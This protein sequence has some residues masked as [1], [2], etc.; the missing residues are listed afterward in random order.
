MIVENSS[1]LSVSLPTSSK[2]LDLF[3]ELQ[4]DYSIVM[5][6]ISVICDF[7]P[8][9]LASIFTFKFYQG[10]EIAHP[11]YA[12]IFMN[13]LISTTATYLSFILTLVDSVVNNNII[14][15]ING[16]I[17]VSSIF[18]SI[19]S[20]MMIAFIRYYLLVHVEKNKH[21]GEVDIVKLKNISLAINSFIF[22]FIVLIR[23]TLHTCQIQGFHVVTCRIGLGISSFICVGVPLIVILILNYKIDNYLKDEFK[24]DVN[25]VDMLAVSPDLSQSPLS[26]HCNAENDTKKNLKRGNRK[27]DNI[28]IISNGV[29]KDSN[30]DI[31]PSTRKNWIHGMSGCLS[32]ANDL[33][34]ESDLYGGI[35]TGEI[36][37]HLTK[38]ASKNKHMHQLSIDSSNF[39]SNQVKVEDQEAVKTFTKAIVSIH[40]EEEPAIS[41]NATKAKRPKEHD[42]TVN[43]EEQSVI[44]NE[45]EVLES[46]EN[47]TANLSTASEIFPS[48]LEWSTFE[49]NEVY[50]DSRE[51]KSITKFVTITVL[52]L[53]FL[54]IFSVF[55][56]IINADPWSNTVSL[57]ILTTY[58][59]CVKLLRTFLV[60][61]SSIYCF[62]MIRALF[63]TMVEQLAGLIQEYYDRFRNCLCI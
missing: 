41:T 10:I 30:I 38:A 3:F 52:L 34:T 35:Y 33:N 31:L 18:T 21:A 14:E 27:V 46:I 5:G 1:N 42:L 6:S 13:I 56:R 55:I 53:L 54:P 2:L 43:Y 45:I 16:V 62:D 63:S 57:I 20:F 40:L 26:S 19:S 49:T 44:E 28:E 17:T 24:K 61:V 48:N 39:S 58:I 51:Y 12:V 7:I 9:L 25:N 11:L 32:P 37:L 36:S 59:I 47:T 29:S 60:I 8:A 22:F 4:N 15:H 50:K 23:V